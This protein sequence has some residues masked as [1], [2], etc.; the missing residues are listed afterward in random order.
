LVQVA[1]NNPPCCGVYR[2]MTLHGRWGRILRTAGL[3][4]LLLVGALS[5]LVQ[6]Q[7]RLLRWRAEHLLADIRQIQM[8]KST[9]ADAQRLM[10]RWGKLGKWEGVCNKYQCE[11]QIELKDALQVHIDHVWAESSPEE[12]AKE[13]NYNWEMRIYA[14]LGGRLTQARANFVVKNEIVWTKAFDTWTARK[15][16]AEGLGDFLIGGAW[17]STGF[18]RG[19]DLPLL[20]KHPEYSIEASGPCAGCRDGACTVC[21]MIESHFTPFADAAVVDSLFDFNLSCISSWHEC[22]EPREIAPA[23]WRTYTHEREEQERLHGERDE[24]DMEDWKQCGLP[25]EMLGRDYRFALLTEV[26]SIKTSPDERSMRYAVSFRG[27][28]SLKNRAVFQTGVLK[29]PLIGWP[30]TVLPGG[31]RMTDVKVGSK[32]ILL[33]NEPPERSNSPYIVLPLS[34]DV[35]SYVPATDANRAAL[36]RGFERDKLADLP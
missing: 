36:Q 6:T 19:L 28:E 12:H 21:E 14:I 20:A 18:R 17:G 16:F 29:D 10:Y 22:E 11:Y 5:V 33:F 2:H 27:I 35:C 25:V 7:Q 1:G 24:T 34:S 4:I 31:I 26:A 8:G 13:H 15:V 9:W 30:D 3:V 23:A 32:M